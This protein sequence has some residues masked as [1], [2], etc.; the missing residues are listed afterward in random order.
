MLLCTE[1][2]IFLAL[3]FFLGKVRRIEYALEV[4]M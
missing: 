4:P 3:S 1:R 2:A